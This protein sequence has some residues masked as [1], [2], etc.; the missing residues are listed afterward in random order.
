MNQFDLSENNRGL[1]LE[2]NIDRLLITDFDRRQ[3]A[4]VADPATAFVVMRWIVDEAL[5]D[6]C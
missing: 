4:D 3:A 2:R 1:L 5:R 6:I